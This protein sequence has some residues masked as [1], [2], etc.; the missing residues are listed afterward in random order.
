VWKGWWL[1]VALNDFR[2]SDG[3]RTGWRRRVRAILSP[4]RCESASSA[5]RRVL[6]CALCA[7]LSHQAVCATELRNYLG[8][9]EYVLGN[10]VFLPAEFLR[11]AERRRSH[12]VELGINE[13]RMYGIDDL[14]IDAARLKIVRGSA[15]CAVSLA[16]FSSPVGS[17]RMAGAEVSGTIGGRLHLQLFFDY[18]Q[19]RIDGFEPDV[20]VTCGMKLCA[21]I[22]ETVAAGYTIGGCAPGGESNEGLDLSA[23]VHARIH[24][25]A[26]WYAYLMLHRE[27][28]ASVGTGVSVHPL[29]SI[30]LIIGYDDGSELLKGM[31]SL[32]LGRVQVQLG[33]GFHPVLGV[34]SGVTLAWGV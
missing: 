26:G 10:G 6:A 13:M 3:D 23:F 14:T 28:I 31:V 25:G 21:E 33:S 1:V 20:S 18:R 15:G 19:I 24:S 8:V 30:Q 4:C 34:A 29:D 32:D 12:A 11:G 27:G 22:G 17:E 9:R 5:V 16:Q 7:A 2:R